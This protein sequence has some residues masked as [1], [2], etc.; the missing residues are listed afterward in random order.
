MNWESDTAEVDGIK[1]QVRSHGTGSPVV[2][3]HGHELSDAISPFE[4][5]LA[6]RFHV[7]V[8]SLPGVNKSELPEWL[9]TVDD[10][11]Y[12]VDDFTN[13]LG[14]GPVDL[15]GHGFGGW[16]AVET[17]VR[18]MAAMRRLVLIDAFGIKVSG[19]TVRDIQD[20][21]V[22]TATEVAELAWHDP[23]RAT[24]L[25]WPG[26]Q[27]VNEQEL[28]VL[29]RNRQSVLG[30]GWSP[31]M[32]NPKLLRRLRRVKVPSQLVWGESD[33]VVLPDYGR[34]FQAAIPDAC[35]E[36]IPDAGHY[37]HWEQPEALAGVVTSFLTKG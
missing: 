15:V 1:L 8:P 30:F 20:T 32:H 34:A 13:Q 17:A 14:L 4:V 35:F 23:A 24:V 25:K 29:L 22:L 3:L 11:V 6:Q 12:L 33:R 5:K 37:P 28:L 19:P 21:Y 2:V 9:D 26:A 10:L 16:V 36:V 31:F 27:G 7:I 18:S